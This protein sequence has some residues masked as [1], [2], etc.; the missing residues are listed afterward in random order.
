MP[1]VKLLIDTEYKTT[2]FNTVVLPC[3]QYQ[4]RHQWS[5]QDLLRTQVRIVI[6]MG[7]MHTCACLGHC[8]P[9]SR[10]QQYIDN[11]L[12]AI[13]SWCSIW[14]VNFDNCITKF[15]KMKSASEGFTDNSIPNQTRHHGTEYMT[16]S[17][18]M[19]VT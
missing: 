18:L 15:K 14:F 4:W 7:Y 8:A 16:L 1:T 17:T 5:C 6:K 19:Y 11:C 12:Y 13:V 9:T 3:T 2:S 10:L